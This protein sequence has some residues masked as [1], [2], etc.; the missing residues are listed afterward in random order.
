MGQQSQGD[1]AK[2]GDKIRWVGEKGGLKFVD[3][4]VVLAAVPLNMSCPYV[5]LLLM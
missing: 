2:V 5:A 3:V 1:G 4:V